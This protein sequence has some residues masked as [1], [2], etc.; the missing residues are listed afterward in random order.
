[1]LPDATVVQR[2]TG[3]SE[4]SIPGPTSS[5]QLAV[6]APRRSRV[7]VIGNVAS[8]VLSPF[9]SG[10]STANHGGDSRPASGGIGPDATRVSAASRFTR[11]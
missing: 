8:S 4:G 1:M 9:G 3:D 6:D 11:P 5:V 7:A 10:S 2:F